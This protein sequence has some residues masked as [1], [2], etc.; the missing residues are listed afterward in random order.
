M[1]DAAQLV[2]PFAPATSFAA[3][4]FVRGEANEEACRLVYGW[5]D[6]PY[7]LMLIHG[8]KGCGK[9]HLAHVFA[10]RAHAVFIEPSR[11]GKVTADQ[12][13]AGNHAWVIDDVEAVTEQA[14]LAQLINH[15]R[16]RGDY[17]LLL[18]GGPASQLPF[19]LLDLKSRLAMLPA[20]TLGAPDDALL[21]GVLAKAFA[22]RQLRIAPDVLQFA[23][24][25]LER[26]YEAVQQFADAMDRLSLSRGRAVT[27][28][29]VREAL[30]G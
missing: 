6:W 4:D 8:P 11:I 17:M 18:A 26:S 15:A 2:M 28:S 30:R 21:T 23:V 9:T 13:L 24:T 20:V 27:L 10:G 14:A 22:D 29:L 7:S 5:P 16:A 3:E 19:T 25:R 12:L 1:S